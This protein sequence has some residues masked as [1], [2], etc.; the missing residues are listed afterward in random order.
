MKINGANNF[1]LQ[2]AAIILTSPYLLALLT[3]VLKRQCL[4]VALFRR[5]NYAS[6]V[7]EVEN[8]SHTLIR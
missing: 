4:V 1:P 5:Q 8:Q 7:W 6:Q 2:Q 3:Q